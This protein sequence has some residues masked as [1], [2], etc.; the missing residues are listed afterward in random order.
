MTKEIQ[1]VLLYGDSFFWG[2]NPDTGKR[3]SSSERIGKQLQVLLGPDFEV[4]E[5]G[6]RG[7]TMFG[8]N[9]WFPERDGLAQFGPIFASHLPI[10]TVV[11]MLGT[12]DLNTKTLHSPQDIAA[13]LT[14]YQSKMEYWCKFMGYDVPKVIVVAPPDIDDTQLDKFKSIFAASSALIVE[15]SEEL[16]IQCSKMGYKFLNSDELVK[17]IGADGIH[18]SPE[19]NLRLATTLKNLI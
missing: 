19:D 14:N 10:H 7:R 15:L 8:E 1:S 16:E 13:A 5:E 3:H 12:N 17:S 9:G 11:I 4:V 18:I 2:V 6:H